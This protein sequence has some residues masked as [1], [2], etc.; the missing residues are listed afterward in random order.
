MA[1]LNDSGVQ[2]LLTQP[3]YAVV[4]TVNDDG[5]LHT[6]VVWAD[7]DDGKVAV[8][9]AIG[10]KW[11]TNLEKNPNIAVTIYKDGDPYDYVAVTGTATGTTDGADEHI[12]RLAKKYLGKDE[13]PFRT[14]EEQRIKYVVNADKIRHNKQ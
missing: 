14:P 7:I 13:Y 1:D 8:N 10:R 2:E 11:P 6:A 5:S 3:N 4:S 9:S 12:D